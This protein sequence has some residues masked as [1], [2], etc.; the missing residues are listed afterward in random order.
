MLKFR[1]VHN[2]NN[3][4]VPFDI[5]ILTI[6]FIF[7]IDLTK[8][9]RFFFWNFCFFGMERPISLVFSFIFALVNRLF[10]INRRFFYG[11]KSDLLK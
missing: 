1:F 6:I 3:M 5:A 2:Q 10:F 9:N 4:F 11:K 7:A 8:K